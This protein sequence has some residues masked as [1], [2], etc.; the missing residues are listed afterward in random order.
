M[1]SSLRKELETP[2]WAQN[3][4]GSRPSRRT[5][6]TAKIPPQPVCRASIRTLI[7]WTLRYTHLKGRYSNYVL[8]YRPRRKRRF[9]TYLDVRLFMTLGVVWNSRAN[10]KM[11]AIP[12]KRRSG[13]TPGR[14][15][16]KEL[17]ILSLP[18]APVKSGTMAASVMMNNCK[19]LRRLLQFCGSRGESVGWGHRTFVP[20]GESLSLAAIASPSSTLA[21]LCGTISSQVPYSG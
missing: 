21:S 12:A 3:K 16:W 14:Q 19:F 17:C 1:R 9:E 11:A 2:T 20:S 6:I 13:W 8:Q 18:V 7:W 10:A 4:M 15:H 5:R